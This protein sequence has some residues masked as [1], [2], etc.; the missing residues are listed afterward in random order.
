VSRSLRKPG[1]VVVRLKLPRRT[2]ASLAAGHNAT[3]KVTVRV[4]IGGGTQ[5][6]GRRFD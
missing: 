5:F 1:R 6:S 4:S 2:R 3:V